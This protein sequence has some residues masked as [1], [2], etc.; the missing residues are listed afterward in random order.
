MDIPMRSKSH[1]IDEKSIHLIKSELIDSWVVRDVQGRDYGIDLQLE[2]FDVSEPTGDFIF[3][4]V[5]GTEKEFDENIVLS[6]FPVKTINYALLF[7]VPFFVFYTSVSSRKT[8][9]IWL[10][11]Y[12]DSILDFEN[13]NW[14]KQKTVTLK[15]PN[16][17]D[18]STN[19]EKISSISSMDKKIKVAH[20]CVMWCERY[21][22]SYK[23]LK[24]GDVSSGRKCFEFLY[25]ILKGKY[26]EQFGGDFL[27]GQDE[28]SRKNVIVKCASILDDKDKCGRLEQEQFD[29]L[30]QLYWAIK[31]CKQFAV[32]IELS[33]SIS[34]WLN[35]SKAY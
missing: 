4:Q 25:M 2:R 35:D 20:K 3:V 12:V 29:V 18:I 13:K 1:L 15:F 31:M 14:K 5:K 8:K 32:N 33:E 11:K 27:L 24:G 19:M 10:Q 16:E 23:E 26:L 28:I 7:S 21:L 17:N 9:Y 6:N 30:E 34:N 22:Y